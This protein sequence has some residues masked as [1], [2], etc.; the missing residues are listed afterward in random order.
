MSE[1]TA[2]VLDAAAQRAA[3]KISSAL[4][5]A[6]KESMVEASLEAGPSSSVMNGEGDSSTFATLRAAIAAHDILTIGYRNAEGRWSR[7]EARPLG[8]TLFENAWLLTIWCETARDFRHLRLD[9]ITSLDTTGRR[10]RVEKGKRFKDAV[11]FERNKL[12]L[13]NPAG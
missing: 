1:R 4:G 5:E 8:L 3:A 12:A 2:S 13:R 9:R 6:Q 11:E 7:R 10:F